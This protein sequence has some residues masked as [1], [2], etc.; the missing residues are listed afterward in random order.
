[1]AADTMPTIS[2]AVIHV[3]LVDDS[4]AVLRAIATVLRREGW[5]VTTAV[6]GFDAKEKL[7][8]ASFDVI[9]SDVNM[10]GYGGLEFLRS[11]RERD[12]DV[13]VILMTGNPTIDSSSRAVEYGAFRYLVKPVANS[14]LVD[15]VGQAARLHK[16]ASLK[17]QSIALLGNGDLRLGEEAALEVQFEKSIKRL[18]MAFQPIVSWRG[19]TVYGNEALLR[20]DDPLMRNPGDILDASER[21]GRVHELGRLVRAKVS[22]DWR[23]AEPTGVSVFVN[24]HSADLND[25]EL[26]AATSP[27]STIADS[28]VLEITERASLH[29]VKDVQ[30]RIAKLK[31][32]GFRIAI[33][34]LGA[35]YA[36]LTSFVALE[37][38]IAKLDM[39]L[40]RGIDADPKRQSIVRSMK[41][42]CDELGILVITEGIETI[43]ERDM[44]ANLGCDLFQGYLFSKPGRGFPAPQW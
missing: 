39:S 3:L 41:R 31:A 4:D 18:W 43:A 19:R 1:M 35:G 7:K 20:S 6:D 42:L 25:D 37:P 5:L 36:G 14:K 11:V 24:L 9:V 23:A 28:V 13:P 10:P 21:L 15:L 32:M 40:V 33:D 22:E 12:Q 38:E 17:R 16:I 44:L 34:D 26:Y 29:D 8:T 27:L 30:D 2:T